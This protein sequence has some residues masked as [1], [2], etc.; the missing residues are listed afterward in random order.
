M[1]FIIKTENK[2]QDSWSLYS[3]T[4]Y[5]SASEDVRE[6]R[7]EGWRLRM[8]SSKDGDENITVPN[9]VNVRLTFK[10]NS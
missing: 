9:F 10:I 7:E 5:T 3:T 2:E 1:K 4:Y 8:T 6:G